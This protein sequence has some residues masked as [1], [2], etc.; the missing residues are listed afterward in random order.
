MRLLADVGL[1]DDEVLASSLLG[2]QHARVVSS[3]LWRGDENYER[4]MQPAL[5]LSGHR[6]IIIIIRF[7]GY[8]KM[9]Y[10]VNL[11]RETDKVSLSEVLMI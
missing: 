7:Y 9:L 2:Q 10:N 11:V 8:S 6:I 5:C 4:I 1:V 3:Q